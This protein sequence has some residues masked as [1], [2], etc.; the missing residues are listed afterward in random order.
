MWCGSKR[1]PAYASYPGTSN[2]KRF[3]SVRTTSLQRHFRLT[4][5]SRAIDAARSPIPHAG[6]LTFDAGIHI[7]WSTNKSTA[8]PRCSEAPRS[9]TLTTSTWAIGYVDVNRNIFAS[10]ASHLEHVTNLIHV[11]P[12]CL[13]WWSVDASGY[14]LFG[15]A[16]G[17]PPQRRVCLLWCSF[18][19]LSIDQIPR[20]WCRR[21]R[22]QGIPRCNDTLRNFSS[23]CGFF[24]HQ[25]TQPWRLEASVAE[26]K[27][28]KKNEVLRTPELS[29]LLHFMP[30]LRLSAVS[31]ILE[32]RLFGPFSI[33]ILWS[34]G[35]GDKCEKMWWWV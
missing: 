29:E 11:D 30:W 20:N 7:I 15:S 12:C 33:S 1:N 35:R 27:S 22:H 18:V 24:L 13:C 34:R 21:S 3:S 14:N 2:H 31:A 4:P 19:C 25:L 10:E 8:K 32:G 6:C 5:T 23:I 16:E 9:A 17:L 26:L 28:L